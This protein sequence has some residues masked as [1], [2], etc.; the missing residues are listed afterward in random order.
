MLYLR[1]QAYLLQSRGGETEDLALICEPEK[2]GLDRNLIEDT[3]PI[4]S[5]NWL[6][7][8]GAKEKIDYYAKTEYEA[9]LLPL[10][11]NP[12]LIHLNP[13]DKYYYK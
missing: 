7:Y 9:L 2:L 6:L 10:F 8:Y 11:N 5:K 12:K 1:F 4:L 3:Y 13:N